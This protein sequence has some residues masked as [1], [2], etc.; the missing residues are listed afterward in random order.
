MRPLI[1]LACATSLSAAVLPVADLDLRVGAGF[2]GRDVDV[3]SGGGENEGEWDRSGRYFAEAL[4]A[5]FPGVVGRFLVG[6]KAVADRSEGDAGDYDVLGV[7]GEIGY[8]LTVVPLLRIELLPYVGA[9]RATLDNGVDR[10][11][12]DSLEYGANLNAVLTAPGGLQAGAG[13]GWA[14]SRS[15]HGLADVDQ[16]GP[17]GA[18]FVGFRL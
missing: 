11:E 1:L 18:L 8:G 14:R 2:R 9:G 15:E 12:A 6:V 16:S 4:L 10:D 13:V 3:T 5:P 17:V 7:Q